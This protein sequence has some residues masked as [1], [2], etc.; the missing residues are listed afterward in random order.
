MSL[1]VFEIDA[2]VSQIE[3]EWTKRV[4]EDEIKEAVSEIISKTEELKLLDN[5]KDTR[6][7]LENELAEVKDEIRRL[8]K[9]VDEIFPN[10]KEYYGKNSWEYRYLSLEDRIRRSVITKLYGT[11]PDK[12]DI[13]QKIIIMNNSDMADILAELRKEFL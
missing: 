12:S 2:L 10:K 8:E 3:S 9:E 13:R 11:P 1:R 7:A 4:N 6:K 5:L